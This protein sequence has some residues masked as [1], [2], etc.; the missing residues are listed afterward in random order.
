MIGIGFIFG[1]Q[2]LKICEKKKK[3]KCPTNENKK[4]KKWR[5]VDP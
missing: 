3:K 4:V 2:L 1:C 5:D